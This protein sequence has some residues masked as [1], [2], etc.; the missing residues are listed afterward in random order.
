[1]AKSTQARIDANRRYSEKTYK[2]VSVYIKKEDVP[3]IDAAR[4]EKSLNGYIT[5]AI[6]EKI[7]RDSGPGEITREP[8]I[9]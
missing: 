4:G 9:E 5:E 1:M 8:F 7:D 6:Y 3:T 2:R